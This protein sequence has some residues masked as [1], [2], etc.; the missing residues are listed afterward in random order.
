MNHPEDESGDL[1]LG[2]SSSQEWRRMKEE[3]E[4]EISKL[5]MT[6]ELIVSKQSTMKNRLV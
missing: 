6:E 2:K 1:S 5:K 3:R 4:C